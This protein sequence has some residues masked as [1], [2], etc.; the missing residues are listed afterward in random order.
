MDILFHCPQCAKPL[1]AKPELSGRRMRCPDC[2][3]EQI[4]PDQSSVAPPGGTVPS[5]STPGSNNPTGTPSSPPPVPHKTPLREKSTAPAASPDAKGSAEKVTPTPSTKTE[6]TTPVFGGEDNTPTVHTDSLATQALT[7][8][9]DDPVPQRRYRDWGWVAPLLVLLIVCGGAGAAA[10]FQPPFLTQLFEP[11]SRTS[12]T[13]TPKKSPNAAKPGQ[14]PDWNQIAHHNIVP[15]TATAVVSLRV[16]DLVKNM[17]DSFK[18]FL[19]AQQQNPLAMS[20]DALGVEPNEVEQ[21]T[22]ATLNKNVTTLT[23]AKVLALIKLANKDARDRL[24]AKITENV[25]GDS[26][27]AAA[28]LTI[29]KLKLPGDLSYAMIVFGNQQ[30]AIVPTGDMEIVLTGL[31]KDPSKKLNPTLT[32]ISQGHQITIVSNRL[33][34]LAK[35]VEEWNW[36]DKD[37]LKNV[38]HALFTMDLKDGCQIVFS[39]KCSDAATV[40]QAKETID[41]TVTQ[42]NALVTTPPPVSKAT[43]AAIA[44]QIAG[45]GVGA[46]PLEFLGVAGQNL[47]IRLAQSLAE[48]RKPSQIPPGIVEVGKVLLNNMNVTEEDNTLTVTTKLNAEQVENIPTELQLSSQ[49]EKRS[50]QARVLHSG[51]IKASTRNVPS[52]F[53]KNWTSGQ[54]LSWRVA[55]LPEIGEE[56]LYKRFKL[57]E[58]WDSEHNKKLIDEMPDLFRAPGTNG[59]PGHTNYQLIV[60]PGAIFEKGKDAALKLDKELGFPTGHSILFAEAEKSVPW[61]KPEDLTF[62]AGTLPEFSKTTP[63]GFMVVLANGKI[64]LVQSDV[65]SNGLRAMLTK[66]GAEQLA[67]S[68]PILRPTRE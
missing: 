2:R 26:I 62:E 15:E 44:F 23:K 66:T 29:K 27:P 21:M 38:K 12:S 10:Y 5:F 1:R 68:L 67:K 39:A 25:G 57:D 6:T 61:T 33:E 14:A 24:V 51:L 22:F 11:K 19:A 54:G 9:A 13:Q 41:K 28:G 63:E 32:A 50:V 36:D 17:P 59:P 34:L 49:Q 37:L 7:P 56:D 42:L 58:P 18:T 43:Q 64:L 20:K 8:W 3:T 46:M 47:P 30:L 4:I 60:G 55:I 52:G 16:S 45:I 31:K 48:P 35:K 53:P 40:L 65:P